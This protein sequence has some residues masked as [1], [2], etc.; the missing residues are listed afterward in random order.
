MERLSAITE[1]VGERALAGT[2]FQP[3][4]R[5]FHRETEPGFVQIIEFGLGPSW[6]I[7]RGQFTVDVCVFIE[8]VYVTLFDAKPPRRPTP[9]HCDLRMRL[10]M[11]DTPPADRWWLLSDPIYLN[12]ADVAHR[13]SSFGLPFLSRLPCRTAFVDEWRKG[14]SEPLGL[15]PRGDLVAAIVLKQ[16]GRNKEVEEVLGSA[17]LRTAGHPSEQFYKKIARKLDTGD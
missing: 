7:M 14:G 5:A 15:S 11:L 3:K 2:G 4:G 6:S 12:V 13:I 17:V 8:E 10:G 16:I 9:S 1:Q